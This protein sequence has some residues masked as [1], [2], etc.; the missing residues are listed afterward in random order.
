MLEIGRQNLP[1]MISAVRNAVAYAELAIDDPATT[2]VEDWEE[3]LV[4]LDT[5]AD[6]LKAEY[7]RLAKLYPEMIS[8]DELFMRPGN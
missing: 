3:Y 7:E 5:L 2:D 4:S 1:L 8:Y 6:I